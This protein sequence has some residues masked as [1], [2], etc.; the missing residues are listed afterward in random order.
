LKMFK[1]IVGMRLSRTRH[2]GKLSVNNIAQSVWPFR[3]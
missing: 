3:R 1:A 2:V